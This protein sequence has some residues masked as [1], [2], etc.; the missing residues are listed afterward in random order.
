MSANPPS[1]RFARMSPSQINQDPFQGEF[2][3]ATADL[4]ER[5]I[6][7]SIQNSLDARSGA[8]KVRVRFGFSGNRGAI[9]VRNAK[10]YLLGL[11]KHLESIADALTAP[12]ANTDDRET[13]AAYR[14]WDQ[15]K[16]PLSYLVVEDFG[17]TGLSGEITAN[18]EIEGTNDFWGF[19]RSI[20]ISPKSEN[21]GGSWG[22][23]K[24]VFPDASRINAYFGLTRRAEEDADLMMGMAMLRTH[25]VNGEKYPPYGF[26][27]AHSDKNDEEWLPMPVTSLEQ[28]KAFIGSAQRDFH[29]QR[30]HQAGLSVVIPHPREDL[31][32]RN[33]GRAVI[34]QYFLPIIR[35]DLEVQIEH[36]AEEL[37]EINA[38]TIGTKTRLV[39]ASDRDDESVISMQGIIRLA[40]WAILQ[41]EHIGIAFPVTKLR[42]SI[43][44]LE[45]GK[46]RQQFESGER[47]AFQ[48]TTKVQQRG[49]QEQDTS[50]FVYLEQDDEL[51]EGCAYFVRGNL[52][53]PRMRS[54]QR[55]RARALV[56]VKNRSLLG[57]LLRDAEGPAHA[58][59]DPHAQRLK[60]HWSGGYNR[61]Q[62]VRRTAELLLQNLVQRTSEQQFDALADLFPADPDTTGVEIK[63]GPRRTPETPLPPP[64][65]NGVPLAITRRTGGFSVRSIDGKAT[66]RKS[67]WILRFAYDVARG[68]SSRAMR[69]YKQGIRQGQ[70]DFSLREGQ[71]Q[72]R[73][74][75][76]EIEVIDHNEIRF[77]V[78]DRSFFVVVDGLDTR[79]VV[80]EVK[81]DSGARTSAAANAQ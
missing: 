20:G 47:L 58:L 54:P 42:E 46:L 59:W 48:L 73:H 8:E 27:A 71:L 80:V 4:S 72:V 67:A 66:E 25:T 10:P 15:L 34:T 44:A 29:L 14:A 65:P 33:L 5:L 21:A 9:G 56:L 18:S 32:P 22:L 49:K 55:Y 61:V 11:E 31:N 7:E 63:R 70:A 23:G 30:N 19:F 74:H 17:T 68:G 6:R 77:M 78:L 52:R 38:A 62:A 76:C 50:Y 69:Q 79:D 75:G 12:R 64:Q 16:E 3:T 1:W 26:F 81:R 39:T 41:K 37:L 51:S 35:G 60:E 45:L 2:F 53:I 36:P 28:D 57:H 40:N 43:E 13:R 24:W